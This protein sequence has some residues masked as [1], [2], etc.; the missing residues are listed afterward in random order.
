M[1]SLNSWVCWRCK[2]E[3]RQINYCNSHPKGWPSKVIGY[4]NHSQHLV[5]DY[6][7][8]SGFICWHS[9]W[10]S[11][12]ERIHI[13][14]SHYEGCLSHIWLIGASFKATWK[15]VKKKAK[16]L[17]EVRMQRKF[18][19]FWSPFGRSLWE[20]EEIRSRFYL[21]WF[22]NDDCMSGMQLPQA[23]LHLGHV[24]SNSLSIEHHSDSSHS[25]CSQKVL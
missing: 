14:G 6:P 21:I 15:A 11:H 8:Q 18:R 7:L 2:I 1:W 24:T 10:T 5:S 25:I 23:M 9:C 13:G 17:S 3:S 22:L 20:D 4:N 16:L 12:N 19:C